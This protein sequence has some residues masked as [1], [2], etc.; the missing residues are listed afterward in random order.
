MHGLSVP[1]LFVL[2]MILQSLNTCVAQTENIPT[3]SI[4]V[5]GQNSSFF[6]GVLYMEIQIMPET[7]YE[8]LTVQLSGS[9][10][11]IIPS[12]VLATFRN[13]ELIRIPIKIR[14]YS[15]TCS[16]IYVR[17]TT[18]NGDYLNNDTGEVCILM[19]VSVGLDLDTLGPVPIPANST[20]L[21]NFWAESFKGSGDL[22]V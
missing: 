6:P 1:V 3:A 11:E 10:L 12:Q 9:F 20:Y 7:D 17:F 19:P 5:N 21:L 22:F 2:M 18:E 15:P 4:S 8:K 14:A 16:N 13:E